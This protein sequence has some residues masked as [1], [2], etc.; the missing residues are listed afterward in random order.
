M[1]S[2]KMI[3]T[4][5][6]AAGVLLSPEHGFLFWTPLAVLSLVGLVV[7]TRPRPGPGPM[8]EGGDDL[9]R[10]AVCCLAMV[11]AQVYIAGS[12]DS[13]TVAGAF[14]QRRFVSLTP[15]LTLGLAALLATPRLGRAWWFRVAC[16]MAV[17][18]NLGLMAQYGTKMMD[19]QRLEPGRNAYNTFVVLPR[20][21][22]SLAYR[23]VFDRSSFYQPTP[24]ERK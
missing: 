24:W 12:V 3:W 6:H 8:P 10:I 14:G 7:M 2:R 11:A 15:I 1:V 20:A 5:P 13:W 23:Y 16:A 9:R 4:S 21:L 18:W 22:P 19:R 17:W